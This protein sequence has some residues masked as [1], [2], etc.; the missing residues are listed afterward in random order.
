MPPQSINYPFLEF[1]DAFRHA[2]TQTG[3]T[4]T[5]RQ[6]MAPWFQ[7][8]YPDPTERSA[9]FEVAMLVFEYLTEYREQLDEARAIIIG[10]ND[11][12]DLVAG[13]LANL[14]LKHFSVERTP[15]KPDQVIR[16]YKK[17]MDAWRGKGG[18]AA[19]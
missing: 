18:N 6:F 8:R 1:V 12:G 19:N 10:S 14:L 5:G 17:H 2:G 11:S 13:V 16:A 9:K 3:N 4:Q 7:A 15:P